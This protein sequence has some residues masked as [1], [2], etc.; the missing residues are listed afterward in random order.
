MDWNLTKNKI[1][2]ME[3]IRKMV[4]CWQHLKRQSISLLADTTRSRSHGNRLAT[5]VQMQSRSHEEGEGRISI[6]V[7]PNQ[8]LQRFPQWLI[9]ATGL[10]LI[11]FA[12]SLFLLAHQSM[13]SHFVVVS[14]PLQLTSMLLPTLFPFLR[15]FWS[16]VWWA[17]FDNCG[18]GNGEHSVLL[19]MWGILVI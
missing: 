18:N 11:P 19:V 7:A 6:T 9:L 4:W 15:G 12:F 5:K 16:G 13:E 14:M 3:K 10:S 1:L 17:I 2:A 8:F